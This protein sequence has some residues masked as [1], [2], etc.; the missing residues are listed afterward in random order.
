MSFHSSEGY[1]VSAVGVHEEDEE[2]KQGTQEGN[3]IAIDK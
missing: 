1:Y 2:Y 3:D